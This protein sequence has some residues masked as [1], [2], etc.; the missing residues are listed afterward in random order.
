MAKVTRREFMKTAG[1]FVAAGTLAS[2]FP[3]LAK[4]ADNKRFNILF[5]MTDQ[6][7]HGVLGCAGNPMVKTPNLDKL[8]A[9]G[10]MFTDA[11]CPTPFCSPTRASIITGMWPHT[12]GVVQNVQGEK[13]ALMDDTVATE[14]ILFDKGYETFQM[15]KWHLGKTADMRCYRKDNEKLS[16]ESHK[17]YLKGLSENQWDKARQGEVQVGDVAMMPEMAEF[18]K[19]WTAETNRSAQNLSLIGRQL[20]K[21]EHTYESWLADRCIEQIKKYKDDNF[22]ITWSVS[23]PHAL[24]IAPEPYYSMYDPAKMALPSNFDDRPQVYANTQPGR[25]GKM[26]GEHLLKEYLRCYYAQ[27]SMMDALVGKILKTLKDEGLDQNT[28]VVFTSDHGDMQ[29]GHGVPGKSLQAFYEEIVRVPL[30]MRY[31]KSIKAGTKL[32]TQVN[33]VDMMPTLLDFAGQQVAKGVQGVSIKSLVEGKAAE[34][35]RPAFCERG[36]GN[37]GGFSRMIRTKEWKYGIWADGRREL[38]DLKNDPGEVTN[39]AD[40]KPSAMGDL[41]KRLL[42]QMEASK[43]PALKNAPKA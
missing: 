31:P 11:I 4:A 3:E 41:H 12:H 18:S 20:L 32:R 1:G 23:P 17:R 5:M 42:A 22:M 38:F 2:Q 28:L 24:W 9:D 34:D 37:K 33:L 40:T 27:V 19:A 25:M 14:Q 36:L 30:L 21:A 7:H 8:A 10:A 13:S 26:M 15:G 29:A 16:Q 6:H 39:L 35:D 43:D